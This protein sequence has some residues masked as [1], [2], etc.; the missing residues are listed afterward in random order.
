MKD[1]NAF[2]SCIPQD[3]DYQ[4]IYQRN[5]SL[6]IKV[7]CLADALPGLRKVYDY[8]TR[9]NGMTYAFEIMYDGHPNTNVVMEGIKWFAKRLKDC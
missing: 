3:E 5:G 2:L 1:K 8:Y 9:L 4:T 7:Y 6:R